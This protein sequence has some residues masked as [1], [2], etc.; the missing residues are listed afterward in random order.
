MPE[1][2]AKDVPIQLTTKY[3]GGIA[4]KPSQNQNVHAPQAQTFLIYVDLLDPDDAICPG[5]MA[6]VKVHC[7]WR[8]TAWWAWRTFSSAFDIGADWRMVL[9][10]FMRSKD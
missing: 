9:P 10:S 7:R 5:T 2:E 8:T 3:G 1:S 4:T 6:Y